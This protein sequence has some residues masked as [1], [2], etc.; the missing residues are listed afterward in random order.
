FR[1]I[2]GT[3][4]VPPVSLPPGAS[5]NETYAASAWVGFD[6]YTC[7]GGIWQ[8]GV[9]FVVQDTNASYRA[10]SEWWIDPSIYYDDFAIGEGDKIKV[11]VTA[12]TT[13]SGVAVIENLSTGEQVNQT[14]VTPWTICEQ[15]ADWVV[16]DFGMSDGRAKGAPFADFGTLTFTDVSVSLA[17]GGTMG[18]SDVTNLID[19]KINETVYTSTS[20]KADSISITYLRHV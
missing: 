7:T 19:L 9:D 20:V 2:T 15:D 11:T 6:G 8:A 13:E 10:W 14:L 4:V 3:F 1:S 17:S 5:T 16:E 12:F 18:P